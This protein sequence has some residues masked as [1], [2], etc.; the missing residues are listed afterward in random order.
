MSH[1]VFWPRKPEEKKETTLN[2]WAK[3]RLIEKDDL[4]N[5]VVENRR[6]RDKEA[7]ELKQRLE[8]MEVLLVNEVCE[9]R[10]ISKS[11][12]ACNR[13]KKSS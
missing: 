7:T 3:K 13:T 4:F 2:D 5:Y 6:K 9:M 12:M 11:S 1:G 10:S 8:K